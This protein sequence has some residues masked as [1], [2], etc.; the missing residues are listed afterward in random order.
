MISSRSVDELRALL[1]PVIG[2]HGLPVDPRHAGTFFEQLRL[3]SGRLAFKLASAAANQ[4]TEV[5]GL[6]L[7]RLYLDYQGALDRPDR[8]AAGRSPGAVPGRAAR[9]VVRSRRRRVAC[10][11]RT[12]RCGAWTRARRT[13]TCRLVEVKCYSAAPGRVRLRAARGADRR[14]SWH[15]ASQCSAARFDPAPGLADRPD[16]AVR[17][18]ELAGLLRFYL[19]RAVRH[20]ACA[21]TPPTRPNGCSATWTGGIPAAVHPDRSHLR[22][23]RGTGELSSEDGGVEYHRIGRDLIEELLDALPTDPRPG[24]R[25]AMRVEREHARCLAAE[26]RA[27]GLPRARRASRDSGGASVW[28]DRSLAG[29]PRRRP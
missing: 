2:Q 7:A 23:V 17:N 19:G 11:A 1:S 18:A 26:A 3:L 29:R 16:R 4:R 20:D 9:R 14:H 13:I 22:P 5:L 8:A 21:P 24:G 12:S 15:A 28:R 6:A 27:R 25:R 10:S